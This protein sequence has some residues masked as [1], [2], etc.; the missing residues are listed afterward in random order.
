MH[1]HRGFELYYC[2]HGEREY[3]IADE[4]YNLS[5]GD[6]VLVPGGVLHRTA[7]K[8][9]T[10]FLVYFSV[11][12]LSRFFSE[13][14]LQTI[15]SNKS[16]C[17]RPDD[18]LRVYIEGELGSMLEE[19]RE[20]SDKTDAALAVRLCHLLLLIST[21]SNNY[22]RSSFSD[23]NIGR[24]VRYINENYGEIEN[25]EDIAERFFIS[26]YHLC[27]TFKK[28]LG[29]SLV[30]YLNTIK[31]RAA[32]KL[33]RDEKLNLTEI[34]TRC[35]FNSSSYFCKVFKAEKRVSPSAYRKSLSAN[36]R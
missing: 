5:E 11:D 35:G 32:T 31:I 10:R 9:A 14:L 26:K 21:S 22:I 18:N 13:E 33:M 20:R 23:K 24:I 7:G 36:K 27:R 17:F 4:F 34:A 16:F 12:F 3:F 30:S 19:Y 25:I 1:Y 6:I 2:C 28:S 8:G 29:V 15:L